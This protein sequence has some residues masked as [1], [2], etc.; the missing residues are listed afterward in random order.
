MRCAGPLD[1][2]HEFDAR[3]LGRRRPAVETQSRDL[4]AAP[5]IGAFGIDAGHAP[6]LALATE[7]PRGIELHGV[8]MVLVHMGDD[9]G[10]GGG[11]FAGIGA[12]VAQRRRVHPVDAPEAGDQMR[13]ARL[14][15]EEAEIAEIGIARGAG[16]AG[17]EARAAFRRVAAPRDT[18]HRHA[19][20]GQRF[21]EAGGAVEQQ[22]DARLGG[23]VARMVGQ[24]R[25]QQH[26]RRVVQAGDE[27]QRGIGLARRRPARGAQRGQRRAVGRAY[28]A[29]H[30]VAG[31]RR[32]AAHGDR[33]A[34]IRAPP[35]PSAVIVAIL[36]T[37]GA[38]G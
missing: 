31:D 20:A 33:R 35:H 19:R 18:L 29:A 23:D 15:G 26:R 10:L 6:A 11:E 28:Q 16:M 37:V 9:A 36:R 2:T 22:R 7:Q 24:P 5:Q 34:P 27:D 12:V 17:E 38:R 25:D 30:D 32:S 3:R 4:A 1:Q 14:D 13:R 21:V 8:G